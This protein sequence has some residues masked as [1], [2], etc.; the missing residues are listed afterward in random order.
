MVAC[1]AK[2]GK[3]VHSNNTRHEMKLKTTGA[4]KKWGWWGG[5]GGGDQAGSAVWEAGARVKHAKSG[6][7]LTTQVT[8]K[9]VR[10]LHVELTHTHTHTT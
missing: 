4:G 10:E 1:H 8:G 7:E 9:K 2:Q 3:K 5:G 6:A